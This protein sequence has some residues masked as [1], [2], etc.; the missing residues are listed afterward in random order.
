VPLELQLAGSQKWLYLQV[1][2]NFAARTATDCCSVALFLLVK[3]GQSQNSLFLLFSANVNSLLFQVCFAS[4]RAR[5]C[6]SL[7]IMPTALAIQRACPICTAMAATCR[8]TSTPPSHDL[9]SLFD[10]SQC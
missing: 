3:L 5:A 6:W 9:I 4:K 10:R 2:F 8:L 7:A 1:V